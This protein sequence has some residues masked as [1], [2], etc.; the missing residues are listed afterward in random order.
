M[1]TLVMDT[2]SPCLTVALFD[3]EDLVAFDHRT[4]GR[5]HAEAL[6]PAV[7]GL[8]DG[9]RAERIWVGCGPGSFTGSRIGIAAARALA[10]AWGAQLEGFDSLTLLASQGR[11]LADSRDVTIACD[12]GHGE[13][14][15]ADEPQAALA[16]S[17]GRAVALARHAIV[18]GDKA[19][20]LIAL[21]GSGQAIAAVIDARE[22]MAMPP[23]AFLSHPQPIYARAPDARMTSSETRGRP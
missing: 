6:L 5:G 3:G 4:I 19:A 9:G 15:L 2:T 20:E 23:Q 21:R 10:F 8:P 14:L 22:A 17:P 13:W 1:R 12:G 16:A 18:A 7:A 11:R